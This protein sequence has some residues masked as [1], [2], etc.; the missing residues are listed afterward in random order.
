MDYSS[1]QACF[2]FATPCAP[3]PIPAIVI[4]SNTETSSKSKRGLSKI[5]V[6][7]IRLNDQGDI[8]NAYS[9]DLI[10]NGKIRKP[11]R[12]NGKLYTCTS[13]M[14]GMYA[15]G[16]RRAEAYQLLSA[17]L[18]TGQPTTISKKVNADNGRSA[19]ADPNGFYHGIAISHQG[20]D[21]ILVGPPLT[22][23]PEIPGTS[24]GY[25]HQQ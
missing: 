24:S 6:Q 16:V 13:T 21:Y 7:A 2:D 15:P 22:I 5:V 11:F 12:F 23:P 9:A 1:S 4:S 20:R 3:P 19:R 25:Q 8:S 14:S 17:A 10:D 18:F